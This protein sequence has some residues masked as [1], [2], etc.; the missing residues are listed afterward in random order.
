MGQTGPAGPIGQTGPM[1]PVG[2]T[3]SV[4]P[5]GPAG[6]T[7]P[8]GPGLTPA[9]IQVSDVT[10]QAVAV[11]NVLQNFV[12][13]ATGSVSGFAHTA[14]TAP[15]TVFRAGVYRVA[16]S[17]PVQRN[18]NPAANATACIRVNGVSV[19]CQ[20]ERL[21][22]NN[23]PRAIPLTAIVQLAAGD[24]VTLAFKG[25]S[26]AVRVTGTADTRT[27]MTIANVD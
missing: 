7:G 27:V 21:E 10:T 6:P 25:T 18:A 13:G 23:V 15:V 26:T 20:T 22:A 5:I 11:A 14:G 3:G 24:V 4:G 2:Q 1:G 17:I 16:A 19:A 8:A 12:W 9:W